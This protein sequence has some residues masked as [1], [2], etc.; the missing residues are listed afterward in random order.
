MTKAQA[1]EKT[2]GGQLT[3]PAVIRAALEVLDDKGLD[4]LSTRA[5]AE[6][7]D[8]RMNTVL[9]HVKTKARMLELMADAILGEISYADLP[10]A[11][12][13]RVRELPRRYRQALLAH[14]DGAALVTGTYTA[15]PHTLRYVDHLVGALLETGADERQAAWTS[16]TLTYFVLGL[17]QEEQG[18]PD[19][20][21]DRLPRA[22]EATEYPALR[23]V[24]GHLLRGTFD[25]RFEFGLD[26]VLGGLGA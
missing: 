11:A 26:A 4:G 25:E 21:D 20:G 9:W 1:N 19:A 10:S 13:Q 2:T 8:V 24:V 12:P 14:R 6:R 18:A 22:V 17:T 5:V 15:E 16:W 3:R 7:L 23:R